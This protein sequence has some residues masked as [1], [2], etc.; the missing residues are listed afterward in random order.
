MRSFHY[1][2]RGSAPVSTCAR[3]HLVDSEHVEGV[4]SHS[5]VERILVDILHQ[6]FITADAAG[7]QSL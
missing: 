4:D 6:V 5:D 2:W 7:F 1:D 3:Q